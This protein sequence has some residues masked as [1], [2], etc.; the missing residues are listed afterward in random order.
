MAE[1]HIELNI[2]GTKFAATELKPK[3]TVVK[4]WAK[5]FVYSFLV[6]AGQSAAVLLGRL[7]YDKGGKSEWLS[8]L[9]QVAGFPV[10]LPFY[11]FLPAN[12]DQQQP[13]PNMALK[14]VAIYIILGL[15]FASDCM[16]YSIGLL[17]LPV[18]TYSL[19]CA[20]QLAFNALFAF[21]LNKQKFSPYIVNSL[22][23]LTIS[24]TLLVFQPEPATKAVTHRQYILGF[25]CTVAAS[26]LFGFILPLTQLAYD[27]VI[28]RDD[29]KVILDMLV[30]QNLVAT[31]ATLIGL[32][33]SGEWKT[34]HG[35]MKGYELG[36]TSYVMTLV[37]IALSWQIFAFGSLKLITLLSSLFSNVIGTLGLPVVPVLAVVIF[38]DKMNGI[39][40]VA[41]VLAI[42]GFVSY[43]YQYYADQDSSN[44][45]KQ[46]EPLTA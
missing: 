38:Q 37:W 44:K 13:Q 43:A 40:A 18:S 6:I 45:R 36:S 39:K 19:I 12:K 3:S 33:A 11:F 9:V 2:T 22:V 21:I 28:K 23:I 15:L 29:F 24:S 14:L 42:W 10:F 30:Y 20:S 41:M 46:P 5:I 7:Y 4:W 17:Y 32:F 16:L 34:L 27:R 1:P 25:I 26:V 8:T 31:C 35:E